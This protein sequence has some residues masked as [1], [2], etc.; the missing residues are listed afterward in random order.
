MDVHYGAS[1][2]TVLL[3]SGPRF[4]QLLAY[5]PTNPSEIIGDLA[6]SWEVSKDGL[7]LTFNLH[8]ARWHD[9]VPVTADD[10]VFS[11]DRMAQTGVTRGRVTAIRDFYE[12]GTARAINDLTVEM[13]LKFAS[14]TA[15]GWLAVDY[16]KIYARHVVEGASQDDLNCCFENN[17]GSGPWIFEKWKKGDS[18]EFVRNNDYFLNPIPFYDGYKV[19]IIEDAA[20]R[21]ASMKTGQVDAWFVMGGTNLVDML[22]LQKETGGKM[23]AVASGAGSVRGFWLNLDMPP[24]DDPRI[25]KAIYLAIDRQEIGEIAAAGENIDG[26]FFPPGYAT[27]TEDILKLPGFRYESNG[28]KHAGDLAE[29]KRLLTEAGFPDG[30]ELTFNVDQAR[31]SR[32]EAEL[33]AVQLKKY[34]NI[35]LVLQVQDRATFYANLRDGSHHLSIIG[36]GLYFLEAQTVLVQWF[37]QDTLR[38]PQNW[39]H[40]RMQELMTAEARELDPEVRVGLFREM[41]DI[42]NKGESHYIVLYWQGRAG[43]IDYR[44]QNF[45]PPYHPHTIWRWDQIWWDPNATPAGGD[46]PP[47][48]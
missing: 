37:V 43:A 27:S 39:T 16:Y 14:S 47:I 34:L 28:D 41:A 21:L 22:Q 36:T 23:R 15:L 20:R 44:I 3:P 5:D 29:A 4:N 33:I 46:A 18:Y 31:Q 6:K 38:N 40:P 25:R 45:R 24:T 9:G 26:N 8:E 2:T 10:V 48:R 17:V 1:S 12:R 32:T 42:L 7:T 19:F 35:D 30:F 11:L 13:P